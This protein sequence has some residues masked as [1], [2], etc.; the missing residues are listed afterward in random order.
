MAMYLPSRKPSMKGEQN[1]LD[2]AGDV[3]TNVILWTPTRRHTSFV[4]A[5]V[6]ILEGLQIVMAN[7]DG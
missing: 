4:Q 7:R 3:E 1:M 2:P 5:L 6:A